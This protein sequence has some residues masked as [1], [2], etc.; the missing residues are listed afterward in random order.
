MPDLPL[1]LADVERLEG[2]LK[3][4]CDCANY[5]LDSS[6]PA[7][8]RDARF[9]AGFEA[10]A[11]FSREMAEAGPALLALAREALERRGG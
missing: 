9:T 4:W 6:E 5:P 7:A 3:A 1:T 11:A 2:L 8:A 10:L